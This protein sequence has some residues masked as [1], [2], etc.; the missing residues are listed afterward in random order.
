TLVVATTAT[1][2]RA[3]APDT[4]SFSNDPLI[5]TPAI[6]LSLKSCLIPMP[7]RGGFRHR[8]MA[9]DCGDFAE[10]FNVGEFHLTPPRQPGGYP[11]LQ[12]KKAANFMA[13]RAEPRKGAGRRGQER[14]SGTRRA[15]VGPPV[16]FWWTHR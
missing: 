14:A 9:S 1:A 7:N 10:T 5:T 15:A 2:P 12:S 6:C 11:V 16:R 4:I 13:F 8:P 3:T